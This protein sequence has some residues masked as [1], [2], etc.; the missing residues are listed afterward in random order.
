MGY[1]ERACVWTGRTSYD[2]CHTLFRLDYCSLSSI[3]PKCL[4]G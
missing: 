2:F 3:A 4:Y 1:V